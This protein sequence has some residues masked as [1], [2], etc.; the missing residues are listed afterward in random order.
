M[1]L[2]Q[3]MSLASLNKDIHLAGTGRAAPGSGVS[4]IPSLRACLEWLTE[5]PTGGCGM[6]DAFKLALGTHRQFL[7]GKR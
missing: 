2:V 5:K 4:S 3:A 1:S 6:T 7:R